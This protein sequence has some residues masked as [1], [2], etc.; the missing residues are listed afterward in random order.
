[1]IKKAQGKK[2]RHGNM[3]ERATDRPLGYIF[4]LKNDG[5]VLMDF[6]LR[7]QR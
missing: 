2:E 6:F 4:W 3:K 5:W 1:M 7:R